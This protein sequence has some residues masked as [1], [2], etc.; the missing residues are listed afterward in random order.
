MLR[1]KINRGRPRKRRLPKPPRLYP[2]EARYLAGIELAL[3]TPHEQIILSILEPVLPQVAIV[4]DDDT[5]ILLNAFSRIR[6]RFR[7]QFTPTD[8]GALSLTAARQVNNVNQKYHAEA[9]NRVLGVNPIMLEPWL[10]Q[11]VKNF[12][13]ENASL[14][15]TLPQE[16]LSDIEQ[17]VFRERKRGASPAEMRA[18]IVEQFGVTQGRA[19]VIARDQVSKFNGRLSEQR[20]RN[21][22]INEYIWRTSKD[23]RVRSD[24]EHL[25]GKTFKWSDPP[26]TV[27][28]GKRAGERN[29]P[30]QD[31][32]C[33]CQAE[34][35]IEALK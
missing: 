28:T 20:Q 9:V 11:E 14:I 32:Q 17:L 15:T 1:Q 35:V 12:I 13:A 26:V 33:R 18:K 25:D 8:A 22:G 34:P 2:I 3:L 6:D 10:E 23:G 27:T 4:L 16:S 21:L 7:Q 5:D 19:K 30:G 31:I 29:H 24:H